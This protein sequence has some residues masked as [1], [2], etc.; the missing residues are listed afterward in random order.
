MA[1]CDPMAN[2][3]GTVYQAAGW[4]YLGQGS[5]RLVGGRERARE[6]FRPTAG[7]AWISEHAYRARGLTIADV[8][9][10]MW[11]REYRPAKHRYVHVQGSHRERREVLRRLGPGLPYPMGD[12]LSRELDQEL[13]RLSVGPGSNG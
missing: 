11:V 3:I 6:Y 8:E 7:G 12:R 5:G 9:S 10:G 2:E 1:Y 13:A 4:T